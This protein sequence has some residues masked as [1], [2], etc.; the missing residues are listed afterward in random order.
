[1][2][3]RSFTKSQQFLGWRQHVLIVS[4]CDRIRQLRPTGMSFF[5]FPGISVVT[6]QDDPQQR[7]P[8]TPPTVQPPPSPR[9]THQGFEP[10]QESISESA[11]TIQHLFENNTQQQ[12]DQVDP[13]PGIQEP[14]MVGALFCQLPENLVLQVVEAIVVQSQRR[15]DAFCGYST[16]N[17]LPPQQGIHHDHRDDEGLSHPPETTPFLA[18]RATGCKKKPG[19]TKNT[20]IRNTWIQ[21]KQYQKPTWPWLS[22]AA[23][24]KYSGIR[25]QAA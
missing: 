12:R 7:L 19:I 18:W 20:C 21:L 3:L 6:A 23:G 22:I 2:Q 25:T 15:P 1:V 16:A 8:G 24:Q 14:Q 9:G 4:G 11:A 10:V 17:H 13:Q 5:A